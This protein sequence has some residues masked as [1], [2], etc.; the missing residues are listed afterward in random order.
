MWRRM[1]HDCDFENSGHSW[2]IDENL[3]EEFS[4]DNE[5]GHMFDGQVNGSYTDSREREERML[6]WLVWDNILFQKG[7]SYIWKRRGSYS[8]WG[9][10][11]QYLWKRQVTNIHLLLTF[12]QKGKILKPQISSS[13]LCHLVLWPCACHLLS[14]SLLPVLLCKA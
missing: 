5:A 12:F 4:R 6:Y 9:Y 11:L 3:R 10:D 13:Q 14:Q 2:Q 8:R 1:K 7:L